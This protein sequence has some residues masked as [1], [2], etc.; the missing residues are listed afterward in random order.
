VDETRVDEMVL[1]WLVVDG[2]DWAITV[3]GGTW[4]V[5][6]TVD[7]LVEGAFISTFLVSLTWVDAFLHSLDGRTGDA[8]GGRTLTG[9]EGSV[10]VPIDFIVRD[11]AAEYDFPTVGVRDS[12]NF[13][14][15]IKD[16]FCVILIVCISFSV[17]HF[18]HDLEYEGWSPWQF[19]QREVASQVSLSWPA[20]PQRA[21][22][23]LPRQETFEWPNLWQLKHRSGLGMYG[24]TGH[25]K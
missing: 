22:V 4:D 7:L 13:R 2:C 25:L 10:W 5:V 12:T 6:E 11:N 18:E 16:I 23:C 1:T 21:H 14:A 9:C 24:L 20:T 3:E 19:M 8:L 17:V 15:S